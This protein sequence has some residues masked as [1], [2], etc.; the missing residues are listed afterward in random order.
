MLIDNSPVDCVWG[1]WTYWSRCT[2]RDTEKTKT[3]RRVP[4]A[5]N[6]GKECS[7][8]SKQTEKCNPDYCPGPILKIK[9]NI[10]QT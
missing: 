2:C 10:L 1:E 8:S 5:V 6:G 9:I 3:R 7:G 4:K